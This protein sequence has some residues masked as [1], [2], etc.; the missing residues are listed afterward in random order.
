MTEC[1]MQDIHKI[2]FRKG[3]NKL[4]KMNLKEEATINDIESTMIVYKKEETD[5]NGEEQDQN[6]GK[7][8]VIIDNEETD[9]L[10]IRDIAKEDSTCL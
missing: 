6:A 3:C 8:E 9:V 10:T 4:R 5:N 7:D 1:G 2:R